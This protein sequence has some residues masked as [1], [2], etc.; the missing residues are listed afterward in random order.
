MNDFDKNFLLS[1]L[2]YGL[3]TRFAFVSVNFEKE[4]E[5]DIVKRRIIDEL[6]KK[7]INNIE[8]IYN[9][10]SKQIES[11]YD[12]INEVR[13]VR[14][15][16]VRTSIDVVRYMLIATDDSASEEIKLSKLNDALSDYVLPQFDRLDLQT[17]KSVF[18]SIEHHLPEKEFNNFKE[19]IGAQIKKP[20]KIQNIKSK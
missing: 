13:T 15:I 6:H 14:N 20:R 4:K 1:E 17:L 11:Y 10:C 7:E 8:A 2:S 12:F 16:G 9:N 18:K 3:I 19:Q 5:K